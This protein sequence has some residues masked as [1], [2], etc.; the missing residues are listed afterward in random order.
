MAESWEIEIAHREV[1]R[2]GIAAPL[3]RALAR[4]K[5]KQTRLQRLGRKF[6]KRLFPL[7]HQILGM[8]APGRISLPN[9][10][11]FAI[12]CANAGYIDVCQRLAESGTYEPD[13]SSLLDLLAPSLDHVL[14]VGAN[15]GYLTLLIATAPGFQGK[16]DAFEVH[17]KTR[18]DLEGMVA[19]AGLE[20]IV[21]C[22]G[23]GL[24]DHDGTVRLSQ[25]RNSVFTR[26][27]DD[28]KTQAGVAAAV[29]RLDGL[30]LAPPDL[31]KMDVEGHEEAV[32]RGGEAVIRAAQPYV[33]FENWYLPHEA[34]MMLA[35]LR[36]L[37]EWGY[38]LFRL[39][40]D[41]Q[42]LRLEPLLAADRAKIPGGFNLL[43]V[44]A[45]RLRLLAVLFGRDLSAVSG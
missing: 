45:S 44:P 31:I 1:A 9:G 37:E 3:P 5:A 6:A 41:S 10:R 16:I 12:D 34:E 20:D 43:A 39:T 17:P 33:V 36:L 7:W 25:E 22:H 2:I 21:T 19:G 15:W 18:R 26:I 29:R 4:V 27:L 38:S 28:N 35:P 8:P 23:V 24:S 11:S 32:L 30:G 40:T 14:D 13:V 42:R